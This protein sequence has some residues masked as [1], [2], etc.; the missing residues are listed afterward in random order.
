MRLPSAFCLHDLFGWRT[1]KTP[2]ANAY[3]SFV[4]DLVL[5][6]CG[7]ISKHLGKLLLFARLLTG[8]IVRAW[9]RCHHYVLTESIISGR[10]KVLLPGLLQIFLHG[11]EIIWVGPGDK[12]RKTVVGNKFQTVHKVLSH[13][14]PAPSRLLSVSALASHSGSSSFF[15]H[16]PLSIH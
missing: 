11:C 9:T 16:S 7:T 3:T 6:K 13:S 10:D 1:R 5:V 8:R 2:S 12:A 14:D 15:M 4:S